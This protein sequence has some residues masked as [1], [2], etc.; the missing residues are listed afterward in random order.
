M[1]YYLDL[2]NFFLNVSAVLADTAALAFVSVWALNIVFKWLISSISFGSLN[3]FIR[4]SI[5]YLKFVITVI[6]LTVV[7]TDGAADAAV[8]V[9]SS[10][11]SVL[12]AAELDLVLVS[13]S[14]VSM[15]KAAELDLLSNP[16]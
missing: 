1:H 6:S 10:E 8:L 13:S 2:L 9:S 7:I 12:K 16:T 5:W 3:S 14:E 11:V 4:L 15:L